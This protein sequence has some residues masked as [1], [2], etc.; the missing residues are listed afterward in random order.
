[1]DGIGSGLDTYLYLTPASKVLLGACALC[2]LGNCTNSGT[3]RKGRQPGRCMHVLL[4]P[5]RMCSTMQACFCV[6]QRITSTLKLDVCRE[7]N[8]WS[9]DHHQPCTHL[10]HLNEGHTQV[11]VG[12]IASPKGP[13]KQQADG[14]DAS[15]IHFGR[16]WGDLW[17]AQEFRE[18]ACEV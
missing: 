11:Q 12:C 15:N 9:S 17:M 4:K 1:L 7:G 16:N 5:S 6:K 10:Q 8:S 2:A 18:R 13:R 14:N 3:M